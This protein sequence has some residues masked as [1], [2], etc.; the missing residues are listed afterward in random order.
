MTC[1]KT[2]TQEAH[3]AQSS[4]IPRKCIPRHIKFKLC[5]NKEK[6]LKEARETKLFEEQK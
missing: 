4:R 5:K 2:Q 6:I 3:R 1:T